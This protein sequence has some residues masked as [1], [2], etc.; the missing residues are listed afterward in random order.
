MISLDL[1]VHFTVLMDLHDPQTYNFEHMQRL[2]D[3]HDK[4]VFAA[5]YVYLIK[6]QQT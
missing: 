1:I 2:C 6:P 3:A 4:F 5:S